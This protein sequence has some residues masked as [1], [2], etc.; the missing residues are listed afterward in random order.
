[1]SEI[2]EII[3]SNLLYI[4]LGYTIGFFIVLLYFASRNRGKILVRV[5]SPM[6]ESGIWVK[7]NWQD[8]EIVMM[9]E[10]DKDSGWK[11][12][13]TVKSLM[14]KS[15]LFGLVHYF[16]VDVFPYA[17]KAIE[18]DCEQETV[19]APHWDKK[20]EENLFRAKVIRAAGE[21]GQK[22]HIPLALYLILIINLAVSVIV[23]LVS[24]GKIKLG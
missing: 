10:K 24:S 16:A 18:Y 21:T 11:F 20:T 6:K 15:R 13:F 7:P 8:N 1:M 2:A 22:L 4:I 3:R 17:P 19:S 9:K 5:K 14:Q 12:T 23:L